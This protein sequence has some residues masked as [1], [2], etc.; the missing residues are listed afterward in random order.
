MKRPVAYFSL[1]FVSILA[2][3]VLV[4]ATISSVCKSLYEQTSEK[5]VNVKSQDKQDALKLAS[6]RF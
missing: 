3:T 1:L 2:S 4:T 5:Q 6:A